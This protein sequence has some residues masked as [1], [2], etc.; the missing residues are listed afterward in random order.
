MKRI[1]SVLI[2]LIICYVLV[3]GTC[4][5]LFEKAS[6]ENPTVLGSIGKAFGYGYNQLNEQLEKDGSSMNLDDIVETTQEI[7]N[8]VEIGDKEDF[9]KGYH[10]ERSSSRS[11]RTHSE[12]KDTNVNT[13]IDTYNDNTDNTDNT[14]PGDAYPEDEDMNVSW[15][16]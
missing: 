12:N 1:V 16:N 4:I 14:Y 10:Q 5:Y 2:K 7:Y 9:K 11:S 15:F 3:V 6:G 13:N 8:E